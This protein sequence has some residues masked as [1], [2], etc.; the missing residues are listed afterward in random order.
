MFAPRPRIPGQF[1]TKLKPAVATEKAGRGMS[2]VFRL[3]SGI[4]TVL[5]L[6]GGR[7]EDGEHCRPPKRCWWLLLFTVLHDTSCDLCA[8][9]LGSPKAVFKTAAHLEKVWLQSGR[10]E[11][12]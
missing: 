1:V 11:E 3:P 5:M 4:L 10:L 7:E 12:T 9:V 6:P 2:L 8:V